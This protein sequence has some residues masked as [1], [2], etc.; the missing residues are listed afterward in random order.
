MNKKSFI[1][2]YMI[3]VIFNVFLSISGII[4]IFAGSSRGSFNVILAGIA[5]IVI[6]I[7]RSWRIARSIKITMPGG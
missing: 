6:S 1:R 7:L 5:I 4:I 3:N 2:N